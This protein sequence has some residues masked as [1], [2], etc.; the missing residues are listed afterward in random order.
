MRRKYFFEGAVLSIDLRKFSLGDECPTR[1]AY[2]S[3]ISYSLYNGNH[4][5]VQD[6][7]WIRNT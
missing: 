4:K 3:V 5:L 2:R 7:R 6:K 1:I